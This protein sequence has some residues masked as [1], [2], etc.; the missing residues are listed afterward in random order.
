MMTIKNILVAMDFGDAAMSA[1]AYGRELARRF[2]A[3][4]HVLHVV[5][6]VGAR[7][8]TSSGLPYDASRL[9]SDLDEVEQQRLAALMTEEDRRQLHAHAVQV[10]SLAPAREIVSYAAR[11]HI[12]L[13]VLGT[14][15]RGPVAHLVMGSVAERVVRTAPCPVLTL[16]H[17][18]HEFI[19]PD[20]LPAVATV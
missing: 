17:H 3:T 19:L 5:D 10:T 8:V 2:D 14:H 18:G 13:I 12:D 6:D 11:A 4:L 15:G 9:Q 7:L 20:A 1:L 16:R